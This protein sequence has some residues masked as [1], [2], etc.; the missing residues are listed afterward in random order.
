[1]HQKLGK[2]IPA[3]LLN[4][5]QSSTTPL[6]SQT[7]S[8]SDLAI[9]SIPSQHCVS[10]PQ[11]NYIAGVSLVS[12][13]PAQ[14]PVAE[15]KSNTEPEM[16]STLAQQSQRQ[17]AEICSNHSQDDDY[18]Y[19][20]V[21]REYLET[22]VTG[23]IVSFYC[24][25]CECQFNDPNAK[26]M[27]TKGKR[28]RLAYK[29]KVDPNLKVDIKTLSVRNKN[30]RLLK[31]TREPN[32]RFRLNNTLNSDGNS[33]NQPVNSIKPLMGQDNS[34]KPQSIQSLMAQSIK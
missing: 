13:A 9:G 23:K 4:P 8:S 19:E 21:G 10:A 12:G 11:V 34:V 1:M 15:Q 30:G 5:L 3:D 28:H 32:T 26:E 31:M 25:L 7:A 14:P 6:Q 33:V 20:P 18:N 16:S 2:P 29:K 17:D 22:R 24:K 27:H